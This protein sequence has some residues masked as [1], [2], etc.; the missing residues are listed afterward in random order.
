MGEPKRN[1]ISILRGNERNGRIELTDRIW[2]IPAQEIYRRMDS[3][4]IGAGKVSQFKKRLKVWIHSNIL[5]E[6]PPD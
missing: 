2:S 5:H 3:S 1:Y 4:I 6:E